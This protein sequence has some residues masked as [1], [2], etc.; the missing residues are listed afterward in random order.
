[1]YKLF[2]R[3]FIVVLLIAAGCMADENYRFSEIE[4]QRL[5]AGDSIKFWHLKQ[6]IIDG[7][8]VEF[9]GCEKYRHFAIAYKS[10]QRFYSTFIAGGMVDCIP[11]EPMPVVIDTGRW[12]IMA[13]P[14]FA[15]SPDTLVFSSGQIQKFKIIRETTPWSIVLEEFKTDTLIGNRDTTLIE[16]DIIEF[17]EVLPF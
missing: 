2:I 10:N 3:C 11:D 15:D 8:N 12:D 7:Q 9:Q 1:M 17:Y 6:Q 13:D 4:L 14:A 16:R 5:F